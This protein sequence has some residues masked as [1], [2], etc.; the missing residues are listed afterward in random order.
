M[1]EKFVFHLRASQVNRVEKKEREK[2]ERSK[3]AVG[4]TPLLGDRKKRQKN[5]SSV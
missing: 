2:V 1:Q 4:D 3:R 5:E